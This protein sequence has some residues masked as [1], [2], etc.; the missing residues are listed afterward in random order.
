MTAVAEQTLPEETVATADQTR[1]CIVT[2]NLLPKTGLI[3][4]VLD[5]EQRV[6]PDL[7][8]NLPGRGL[9]VT[10]SR[11][12]VAEAVHKKLFAKA[13]KGTAAASPDLPD[14]TA[15]LLRRRILDLIGLSK[16]AG[17][18]T[19]GQPQVEAALKARRVALLFLADDAGAEPGYSAGVPCCRLLTRDEL[20]PALGYEQIVY[21][22]FTAHTLTDKLAVEAERLAGFFDYPQQTETGKSSYD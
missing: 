10:S 13:A 14:L 11:A 1:R 7:A 9:W 4:F 22:G 19:L 16:S 17:I 2:G 18:A 8:G 20:G 15:R 5:P 21:A 6:V 12:A 3:R